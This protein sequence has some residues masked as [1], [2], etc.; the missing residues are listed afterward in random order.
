MYS[1]WRISRSILYTRRYLVLE[2]SEPKN[3]LGFSNASLHNISTVYTG[4][5]IVEQFFMQI[6]IFTMTGHKFIEHHLHIV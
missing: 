5:L 1:T 6:L 2:N 3:Y 4:N